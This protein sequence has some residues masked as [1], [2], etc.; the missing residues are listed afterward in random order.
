MNID[1][2]V[3]QKNVMV[4]L[5]MARSGTS[6]IARGLKALG[7]DLGDTLTA[8]SERWN[9]K[10]FFEDTDI[11][12]KINRGALYALD[13]PWM[14]VNLV[15]KVKQDKGALHDLQKSAVALLKQRMA[16]TQY[17]GFKD[18]RTAK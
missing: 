11:V 2:E 16:N 1:K 12:Y 8:S 4:I 18:P 17:W 9:P 15:E 5:G 7:V 6:A 3:P 14:S 13:Y 10:G